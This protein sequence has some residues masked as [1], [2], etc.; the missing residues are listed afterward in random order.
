LRVRG[1]AHRVTRVKLD[2]E[3]DELLAASAAVRFF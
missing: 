1:P 2:D 3:I